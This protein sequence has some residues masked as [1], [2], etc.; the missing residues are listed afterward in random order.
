[1]NIDREVIA[2]LRE[3]LEIGRDA[4]V[5]S[6]Y[7]GIDIAKIDAALAAL[8]KL[9]AQADAASA[10]KAV[11]REPTLEMLWASVC[12]GDTCSGIW[13][14]MWDAAMKEEKE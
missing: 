9:E 6:T 11:P 3:A 8:D 12:A 7:S 14:A 2:Q 10:V 1:M 13:R 5:Y 4:V